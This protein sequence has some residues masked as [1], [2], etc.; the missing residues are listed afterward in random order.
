MLRWGEGDRD[1]AVGRSERDCG[2]F[3]DRDEEGNARP[4]GPAGFGAVIELE[5]LR[6]RGDDRG[7]SARSRGHERRRI[8]GREDVDDRSVRRPEA[9]LHDDVHRS[10]VERYDAVEGVAIGCRE[11]R[12]AHDVVAQER[13]RDDLSGC[14]GGV[15]DRVG[16]DR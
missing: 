6:A 8:E 1:V 11:M 16:R 9:V 13:N 14:N 4:G 15:V 7:A 3:G 10:P 2:R 5:H 12:G